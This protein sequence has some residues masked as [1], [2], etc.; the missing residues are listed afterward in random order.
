M[1]FVYKPEGVEPKSWD[2]DPDKLMNAEAEAIERH[3]GWTYGE[4]VDKFGNASILAIHALLFVFL[5][6]STPTL[7][8]E[9]VQFSMSEVD[10]ELDDAE[11]AK[12]I[13]ELTSKRDAG[14]L[15]PA[16][17]AALA[18]LIKAYPVAEVPKA[19][20]AGLPDVPDIS[21]A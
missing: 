14:T 16:E 11:A 4:F 21:S 17:A 12:A 19:P 6:R 15:E 2:F 3:T 18:E 8:W 10:M 7:L 13:A 9:Q 20:E 5:K 1:R